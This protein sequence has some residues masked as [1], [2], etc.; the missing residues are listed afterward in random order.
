MH[1]RNAR[2]VRT[3]PRHLSD[4]AARHSALLPDPEPGEIRVGMASSE[5]HVTVQCLGGLGSD[6]QESL[7]APL[8]EYPENLAVK[9]NV[10]SVLGM[11]AQIRNLGQTTAGVDEHAEQCL[12]SPP[13]K[14]VIAGVE[15]GAELVLGENR[16][17]LLGDDRRMHV[18]HRA[19]G[20]LALL[21]KPPEELLQ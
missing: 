14:A 2:L 13:F 20:D 8:P 18:L 10:A 15:Q 6:G 17:T 5:P 11:Q 4:P 9:I 21:H 1:S 19:P 3:S 7:P 16:N 12:V